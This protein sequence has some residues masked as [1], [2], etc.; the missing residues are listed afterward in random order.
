M[1]IGKTGYATKDTWASPR[2][3]APCTGSPKENPKEA[4]SVTQAKSTREGD[5]LAATA[6]GSLRHSASW[7]SEQGAAHSTRSS[8][9]S[10]IRDWITTPKLSP[11]RLRVSPIINY[12]E[13]DTYQFDASDA[14][15][16]IFVVQFELRRWRWRFGFRGVVFWDDDF[17][18][19]RPLSSD[20]IFR[21]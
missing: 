1:N 19:C 14:F 2:P 11:I 13:V 10:K 3:K 15:T 20:L 8:V 9:R 4:Y 7:S 18:S 17:D 12:N 16:S 21:I 5:R 6:T